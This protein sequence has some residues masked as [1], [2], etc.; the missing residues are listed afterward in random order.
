MNVYL[1]KDY[2]KFRKINNRYLKFN[3]KPEKQT[4]ISENFNNYN[5]YNLTKQNNVY[6]SNYFSVN[7]FGIY[8]NNLNNNYNNIKKD[9]SLKLSS[10]VNPPKININNSNNNLKLSITNFKNSNSK[11]I[12]SKRD[13]NAKEI[14]EENKLNNNLFKKNND[15]IP[16]ILKIQKLIEVLQNKH[17]SDNTSINLKNTTS[18]DKKNNNIVKNTENNLINRKIDKLPSLNNDIK[19]N[20]KQLQEEKNELK[21]FPVKDMINRVNHTKIKLKNINHENHLVV[22]SFISYIKTILKS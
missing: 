6:N 3:D 17:T 8:K 16:T 15:E 9:N 19:T 7:K 1:N 2:L 22:I 5:K 13:I 18:F 11:L 14:K 21:M 4:I 20:F 12:S 10:L